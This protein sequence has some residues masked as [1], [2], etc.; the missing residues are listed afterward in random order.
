MKIRTF[1]ILGRVSNLPTVWSDLLAGWYLAGGSFAPCTFFT[2][3]IVGSFLYTGGMFLNDFC[4]ADFD[5]QYRP[6]R[7][8][9]AG[10]ISRKTVG[11]CASAGLLLGTAFLSIL[12]WQTLVPTLLLLVCIIF[13]NIIHKKAPQGAPLI[14]GGCRLLLY[15]LSAAAVV[16]SSGLPGT[17]LILA[18]FALGLYVA[19]ITY[20]ARGESRPETSSSWSL[21]FLLLPV[22]LPF[23][24]GAN[25]NRII[26][27]L[28]SSLLLLWMSWLLIPLWRGTN[29]SIGRV[30]AGLLAAI[31][32]VDCIAVSPVLGFQTGWFLIL[33]AISLLLQRIIPAT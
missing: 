31:V 17:P 1:L 16:K 19:G 4:D 20:L 9:P 18:G 33:F 27:I 2:V 26:T 21:L 28:F 22:L 14:M 10:L 5:S 25:Q 24:C 32:L 3:L 12:G 15:F 13:Y 30:V 8:I 23:G 7:P 6:E 11:W 29:R